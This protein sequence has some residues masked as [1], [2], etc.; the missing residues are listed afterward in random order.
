MPPAKSPS[1][2]HFNPDLTEFGLEGAF[3]A[4]LPANLLGQED[5]LRAIGQHLQFPA[6][7]FQEYTWGELSDALHDLHWLTNKYIVL[8][9]RDVPL[10]ANDELRLYLD[11]LYS[12]AED[13]QA[14][15]GQ[16]L[17]ILFPPKYEAMVKQVLHDN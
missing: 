3:V 10:L 15:E 14:L 9:H 6:H 11:V 8:I 12:T 16:G 4:T 5:L 17:L 1:G 13:W 2:I 7:I